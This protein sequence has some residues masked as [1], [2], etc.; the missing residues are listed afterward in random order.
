M[1]LE[2]AVSLTASKMTF[3]RI[4][5]E[6]QDVLVH[7]AADQEGHEA[8]KNLSAHLTS[9]LPCR[10]HLLPSS[11]CHTRRNKTASSIHPAAV[12]RII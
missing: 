8:P 3:D 1:E 11:C 2:K 4:A 6:P 7:Y 12:F 5:F 10:S 9:R